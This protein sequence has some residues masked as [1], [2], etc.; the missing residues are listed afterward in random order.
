MSSARLCEISP[1]THQEDFAKKMAQFRAGCISATF[2]WFC[3]VVIGFAFLANPTMRKLAGFVLLE[4]M[5]PMVH[6]FVLI[7]TA[8]DVWKHS[9]S[10]SDVR[11]RSSHSGVFPH[12]CPA[13]KESVAKLVAAGTRVLSSTAAN[14]VPPPVWE[15]GVSIEFLQSFVDEY[16][17]DNWSTAEIC[18]NVII[19][20]TAEAQCTFW[21]A[22]H[23]SGS[24]TE[25]FLGFPTCMCSHAWSYKFATL[26]EIIQQYTAQQNEDQY[27]F[28]DMFAMN[29]HS[30][31]SVLAANHEPSHRRQSQLLADVLQEN[32]TKSIS[33]PGKV[34]LALDPWYEPVPFTRCWCL[35][36][37]YI[38]VKSGSEVVMHFSSEAEDHFFQ[39]VQKCE[40]EMR[41]SIERI[42]IKNAKASADKDRMMI[43]KLVDAE[44][45]AAKFNIFIR[46]QMQSLLKLVAL[47]KWV[48]AAR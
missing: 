40:D 5:F 30:L 2:P 23:M 4:I 42:D 6:S 15:C 33:T 17:I 26:V 9:R 11:K 20:Q 48:A 1:K 3:S 12:K 39:S 35:Y 21:N 46:E 24:C 14:F 38:A 43:M 16:E 13:E 8:L 36:E 34:L 37:M 18:Q 31:S 25:S 41:D 45:G 19:P 27:F 47:R 7:L 29:Q 10:S 32:L 44:M 22:V 28:L